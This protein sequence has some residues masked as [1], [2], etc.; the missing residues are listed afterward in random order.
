LRHIAGSVEHFHP[1]FRSIAG[2]V[3]Q[4]QRNR[5]KKGRNGMSKKVRGHRLPL[6]VSPHPI[7]GTEQCI[8]VS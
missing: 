1:G 3:P 6:T 5:G 8:S 7:V 4:Q 2:P